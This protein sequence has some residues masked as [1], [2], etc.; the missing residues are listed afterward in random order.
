[1]SNPPDDRE[2]A[3]EPT[4]PGA[5]FV[6]LLMSWPRQFG[7]T[8]EAAKVGPVRLK[9]TRAVASSRREVDF[10]WIFP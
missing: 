5:I 9:V 10:S 3:T 2:L 1:M 7:V 4:K 6:K 8:G